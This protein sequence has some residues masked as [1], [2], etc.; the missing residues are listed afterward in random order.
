MPNNSGPSN[1][2]SLGGLLNSQIEVIVLA[3]LGILLLLYLVHRIT[4]FDPSRNLASRLANKSWMTRDPQL[5]TNRTRILRVS[6]GVIW[7]IDG[8]LQLRPSMPGG[9]VTQVASPSLLGGPGW[10]NEIANPFL[11]LWNNHPVKLDIVSGIIQLLIGVAML[12][13]IGPIA[14]RVVLYGSLIWDLLV[15]IVGNGA[16]VFYSGAAFATG[17]PAAIIVYAYVS[18]LL[19]SADS[20]K[21]W[22]DRL[23]PTAYFAG[24]F[25]AIG[26]L[27]QALPAEGYWQKE[28]LSSYLSQMAASQQP[29]LVAE[30]VK[31]YATLASHSPTVANSIMVLVPLSAAA[32][33]FI[34][35]KSK[36]IVLWATFAALFGWW[37]GQ[38][39]GVFSP[40]GT[41]FNSGFPLAVVI[42]SLLASAEP[43]TLSKGVFAKTTDKLFNL[44]STAKALGGGIGWLTITAFFL[45]GIIMVASVTGPPSASMALVDSGGAQ[46]LLSPHRAPGFTLYNSDGKQ[47][48]LASFSGR[49]VVLTFLDP[50]CYDAC[51]LIAQEMVS[52]ASM[53]G[54]NSSKVALVAIVANPI[55]HSISDV[56][57]FDASHGLNR[58]SNWYY[59]TGSVS[60]LEK[61]WKLYGIQVVVPKEGMVVHS[62][63]VFFISKNGYTKDILLNTA[64]DQYAASYSTTVYQTLKPMV[65]K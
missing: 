7:I 35:P 51:P 57:A 47:V 63:F 31:L 1:Y 26:A 33:L 2:G 55:F 64:N 13:N 4:G 62:Q 40:T 10:V 60:E 52:G 48:S 59:L 56:K 14:R 17:A 44:G 22:V 53:L 11:N 32:L 20:S 23:R 61:I 43:I 38:D 37:I 3:S 16:G 12:V 49:P 54:K 9:F 19:L 28:A 65:A 42:F 15:F 36:P 30:P 41:D 5:E 34:K 46:S 27:L 6:F 25:L 39:M 24:G 29:S 8:V 45:S 18:I 21:A 50:E 58:Y